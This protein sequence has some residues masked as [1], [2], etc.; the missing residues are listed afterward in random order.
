[1]DHALERDGRDYAAA[2]DL[3]A[4]TVQNPSASTAARL[5]AA[6]ATIAFYPQHQE[7]EQARDL[8]ERLAALATF[9]REKE[10]R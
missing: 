8:L 4:E 5:A 3:L 10:R 6:R 7:Q 2:R 9:H 1:L